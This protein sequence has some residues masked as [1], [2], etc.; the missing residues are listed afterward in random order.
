MSHSIQHVMSQESMLILSGAIPSFEM[1]MT[2]WEALKDSH[3][4]LRPVIEAGLEVA[5]PLI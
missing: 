3:S 4:N 1:F 5:Y 2:S